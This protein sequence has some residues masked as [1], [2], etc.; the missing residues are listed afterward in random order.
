MK[1]TSRHDAAW[2]LAVPPP[3]AGIPVRRIPF[4]MMKN[5]S[6]SL[7]SCVSGFRMSGARGY[8]LRPISV[9]PPPSLA[10]HEAHSAAQ[11]AR[12]SEITSSVFGS[13]LF[14][15]LMLSG[16]ASLRAIRAANFSI[17]VGSAFALKPPAAIRRNPNAPMPMTR[18][19]A[20]SIVSG[21]FIVDLS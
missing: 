7:R 12:A 20:A 17:A 18:T 2:D 16:A 1:R 10:W 11:W 4:S 3:Q 6:P 19:T 21:R 9:S 5:N 8:M 15:D 13:G 14:L